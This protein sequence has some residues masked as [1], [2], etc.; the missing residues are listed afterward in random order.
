M[1]GPET[2]EDVFMCMCQFPKANTTDLQY[3]HSLIK[4]EEFK[5]TREPSS[6]TDKHCKKTNK[7]YQEKF[8]QDVENVPLKS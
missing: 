1:C 4:K 7:T 3:K 5:S 2:K 8:I 6:N